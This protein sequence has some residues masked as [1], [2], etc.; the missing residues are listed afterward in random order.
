MLNLNDYQRKALETAIYPDM[1]NNLI[2]PV[3]SLAAEVGEIHSLISK[4]MRDSTGLDDEKL[5]YE[6]GDCLWEL[7][8][9]AHEIDYP[10]D[11]IAQ[12]NIDKLADRKHRGKL[13]G[14]GD[15]R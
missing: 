14:H 15:N 3:L 2:Y 5:A 8:I 6:I 13:S 9:L 10:L 4:N 1:G 12:M 11:H 7:A